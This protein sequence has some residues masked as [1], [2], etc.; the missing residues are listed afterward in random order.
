MLEWM[1]IRV[2][3]E[4]QALGLRHMHVQSRN[5]GTHVE[6][7]RHTHVHMERLALDNHA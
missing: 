6:K 7:K 3:H 5:M 2:Y 4:R 1:V